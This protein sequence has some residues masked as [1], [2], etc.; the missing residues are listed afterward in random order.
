MG[1][2]PSSLL[3]ASRHLGEKSSG[4]MP[5]SR[6]SPRLSRWLAAAVYLLATFLVVNTAA[7]LASAIPS[8]RPGEP[9]WRFGF[10]GL[11]TAQLGPLLIATV[12]VVFIGLRQDHRAVVRVVAVLGLVVALGLL[13]GA[14]LFSLDAI[15]IQRSVPSNG[16]R[17][18]TWAIIKALGSSVIGAVTLMTL[19]IGSLRRSGA[20]GGPPKALMVRAAHQ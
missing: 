17:T 7:E 10:F 13:S 16:R 8:F 18:F 1:D 2:Q 4:F 9:S 6:E 5:V 3:L 14:M 12:A 19:A 20:P 15:E 11:F